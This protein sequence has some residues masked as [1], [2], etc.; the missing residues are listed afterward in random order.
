MSLLKKEISYPINILDP[1]NL[2]KVSKL[3]NDCDFII[4]TAA[5]SAV[6]KSLALDYSH[7]KRIMSFF[8]NPSGSSAMAL[9]E[10]KDRTH[11]LDTI[12][13]EYFK[14][15]LENS[16]HINHFTGIEKIS[17]SAYCRDTS[18]ILSQDSIAAFSALCSKKIKSASISDNAEVI[19]W[20]EHEDGVAADRFQPAQYTRHEA[21][22][23]EGIAW[24]LLISSEAEHDMRVA[25]DAAGCM[26]TGGI[27][28]GGIDKSRDII[29]IVKS[30]PPPDD[31]IHA[32]TS[33][34]RGCKGL[35]KRMNEIMNLY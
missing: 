31:S 13:Y 20:T 28:I 24:T 12:E 8:M 2:E 35:P 4:D 25:R 17:Y 21:I 11:R 22:D 30:I 19:I 10:D 34:I 23:S 14:R 18:A 7:K 32:P 3:I 33:Y 1:V 6:S 15:L 27:L 9:I 5:S 26:E 16:I 29:Y